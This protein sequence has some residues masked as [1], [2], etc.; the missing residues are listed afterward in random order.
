MNSSISI[1]ILQYIHIICFHKRHFDLNHN[2]FQPV[3]GVWPT[4][5]KSNW[6]LTG[7]LGN[8]KIDGTTVWHLLKWSVQMAHID[9]YVPTSP[10]E[11][12][13]ST[14]FCLSLYA[15]EYRTAA[16]I[17]LALWLP[18]F[19][20]SADEDREAKA[21]HFHHTLPPVDHCHW[22]DLPCGL[23]WWE[24][25]LLIHT[26][27][28]VWSAAYIMLDCVWLV[29]VAGQKKNYIHPNRFFKSVVPTSH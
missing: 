17:A 3:F 29:S 2:N 1:G 23:A 25:R 26:T 4:Q 21:K 16:V 11:A 10:G 7:S 27:V 18:C 24:V 14:V 5:A 13:I 19:R 15:A 20:M 28:W 12:D 6:N 22:E 8:F 9:Q